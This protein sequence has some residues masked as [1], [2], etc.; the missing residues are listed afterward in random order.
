[1]RKIKFTFVLLISLQLLRFFSGCTPSEVEVSEDTKKLKDSTQI[2]LALENARIHYTNALRNTEEGEHSSAVKQFESA[3]NQLYKIDRKTLEK[4]INWLKDFNEIGVSIVQDYLVSGKD[5]SESSRVFKL[6]KRLNI[7]Y[8]KVEQKTYSNYFEPKDLPKSNEISFEKNEFVQEYINYF[9]NSGRKYMDK[10]LYR[11][12]KY[13]NLMR[14]IMKENNAPEELI[15]LSMIE[16]GLDPTISS[17]AGAIGLWQFMPTTGTAYGLYYDD[18]TDDKRDPEKSTDAAAKHLKDLYNS[19]GDWYLALASYNAGPGRITSAMKKTGSSD[20]WT[21]RGYL[22]KETR[23]YVPQYIACA[24]ITIDPAAYGFDDVEWGNPVEY[25]RVV[26]KAQ[27]SASRIAELCN[28]SVETI[29]EL[30]S[31]LLKDITPVFENG[32]LIKIPKGTFKEFATNYEAATD[33]DKYDFKPVYEGNEGT[34]STKHVESV[35]YNVSGYNP[36]DRR[37]IISTSKRELIF[38]VLNDSEALPTIASKYDV[39]ASDIRIWNNLSFSRKLEKGDSLSVWITK[40]KYKELFGVNMENE[41]VEESSNIDSTL[42]NESTDEIVNNED[43]LVNKENREE[44]NSDIEKKKENNSDVKKKKNIKKG[45]YQ[46]YTVKSGDNLAS[47]ADSYDVSISE[48]KEW[49]EL[50]SDKI[51]VGQKLKI[52]SDNKTNSKTNKGNKISHK[53]KAGDNL[54][55]IADKYDVAVADIKEWN[56]ITSDV[57]YEGQVLTIY[58]DKQITKDNTKKM[59]RTTYT[60]KAGDNLSGIADEF[61]VTVADLKKWNNLESDNIYAGQVLKL[62]DSKSTDK[63]K[64][65][66]KVQY[67]TVKKND[68]LAKIADKYN[69]TISQLKKWNNLKSE[70]ITIGQKLIVKK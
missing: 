23:N 29:R 62:Y 59:K 50:E 48:I 56:D 35:Y 57:I 4:H 63:K 13:F 61:N 64:E 51:L 39:R 60:V 43:I 20:F 53:V 68:T 66:T 36:E 44:N 55:S 31:Q 67:Y 8:E 3:V 2:Y 11:A 65:K 17:W 47:I 14:S 18:Y 37:Y 38:Y 52:Y 9:Q 46:T 6:A 27:I 25:D 22:P 32:Y 40:S 1:M 54:T 49:N 33:F 12:G 28:T 58:S 24:L 21:I 42:N 10:W 45:S 70:K 30:N 34:A 41:T 15:Y 69:V 19:L 7:T 16:S 5:I 26:I